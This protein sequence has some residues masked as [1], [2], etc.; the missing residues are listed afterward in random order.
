MAPKRH[1]QEGNNILRSKGGEQLNTL[2]RGRG[3]T[4]KWCASRLGVHNTLWSMWETG[5]RVP[6]PEHVAAICTLFSVKKSALALL[7][8]GK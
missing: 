2:R 5:V 6:S 3:L 7:A 1:P 4:G 8:A